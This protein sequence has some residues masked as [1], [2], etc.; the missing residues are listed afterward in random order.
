MYYILL[1][2][3]IMYSI[4]IYFN[5]KDMFDDKFYIRWL[6][7]QKWIIQILNKWMNEE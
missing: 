3:E 2:F 1:M 6:Y 7:Y 5:R 4:S